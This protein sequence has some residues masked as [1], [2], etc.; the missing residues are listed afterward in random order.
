MSTVGVNKDGNVVAN[1]LLF[2]GIALIVLGMLATIFSFFVTMGTVICVGGLLVAAGI[3]QFIHVFR[4]WGSDKKNWLHALSGL[5]YLFAGGLILYNPLA[6]ALSLTFVMS[7]FFIASGVIRCLY[8][9][10]HRSEPT[11]VWFLVGGITNF[12]LGAI[13]AYGWPI[14]GLWVIGLFIGI[15][16]LVHGVTWVFMSAALKQ[17]GQTA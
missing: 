11:W 16:M 1:T 13:I 10:A 4:T 3:A 12:A 17:I 7:A 9:L 5:A 6:G 8:A 15:E 14:T 2:F